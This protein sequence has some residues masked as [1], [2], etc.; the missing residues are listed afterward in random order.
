MLKHKSN[1]QDESSNVQFSKVSLTDGFLPSG[2]S[3]GD[4]NEEGRPIYLG[5]G[6]LSLC[7]GQKRVFEFG[8]LLREAGNAR[9]AT[10]TFRI[11]SDLFDLDYVLRLS[12]ASA[13][14]FWWI[15]PTQNRRVVRT[16]AASFNVLPKPPK[17]QLRFASVKEQYYTNESIGLQVEILNEEEDDS[18]VDLDLRITGDNFPMGILKHS[19]GTDADT[20]ATTHLGVGKLAST[21]STT[22]D[23][24]LSAVEFPAIYELEIKASYRLVSD[25]D[26]P[27]SCT[28]SMHLPTISPFEANYDFSPRVHPEPWPSFFN[29]QESA[30]A[31]VG[32]QQDVTA[33]GLAQKWCLTSR[34]ASFATQGLFIEDVDVEVIGQN[35][36][37]KCYTEKIAPLPEGGVKMLPKTIEE[38]QFS[39][40]TQKNS[41]DDRGTA[42][43]DV[44]LAIKWRRDA[45]GAAVNTTIL[46]VPRLLVSSSEP[47]VLASIS[48]STVIPSMIHFDVTIENPSYHFLTF[49]LSMEP[50]EDFAFSGIKQSTLQLVPISRRTVRFRL[51]PSVRGEW[52]GPVRCIIRD[53]YF[54]KV[55]K[56]APTEGMKIEKD[57]M[58]IWVPPLEDD[59]E[60]QQ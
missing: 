59:L 4:T 25:P 46:Q 26:T 6:S 18:V 17:M 1:N 49:G 10:A 51:L 54:Q 53:R 36:G 57:G 20:E 27:I 50:S 9:A 16:N 39:V 40:F 45:T 34:Y 24:L 52:L 47:R 3:T 44:S 31:G 42:T 12:G 60:T 43:L 48:Y 19:S 2:T 56:I 15:N 14:E 23:I 28:I 5:E 8:S 33:R 7:P 38:A 58:L 35:G 41:L 11:A 22:V 29:H 32:T 13:P 37:I 55:L 30:D 21:A